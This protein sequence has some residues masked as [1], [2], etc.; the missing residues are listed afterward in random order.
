[1]ADSAVP[2]EDYRHALRRLLIGWRMHTANGV[3]LPAERVPVL[4]LV[5][6]WVTQVHRFGQAFLQL[7]KHGYA[8]ESHAIVRSALEQ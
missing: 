6:P 1:M 2:A 3:E 4:T 7:E 5:Y 8:H